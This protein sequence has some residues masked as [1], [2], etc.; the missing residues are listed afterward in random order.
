MQRVLRNATLQ[1]NEFKLRDNPNLIPIIT[2]HQSKGSEFHHV[3]LANMKE[4]VFPNWISIRN[5]DV[6][7]EDRLVYVALT[8]AKKDLTISYNLERKREPSRYIALLPKYCIEE[9]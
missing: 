8:R 3:Y 1:N 4:G 7:E 2:V 5:N 9:V 6:K